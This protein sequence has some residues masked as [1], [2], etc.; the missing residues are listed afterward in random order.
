MLDSN[1]CA[2]AWHFF[3]KLSSS[4]LFLTLNSC[5]CVASG[6]VQFD[7]K[8]QQLHLTPAAKARL[9]QF[10]ADRDADY[11]E[12]HGG[13]AVADTAAAARH[14]AVDYAVTESY[15]DD[16]PLAQSFHQHKLDGWYTW[17]LFVQL[18]PVCS[19]AIRPPVPLGVC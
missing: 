6:D 13:G 10:Q 14:D 7:I 17:Y 19:L 2:V 8:F 16:E 5:N 18:T 15:E 12:E 11:A 4:S 1:G 3:V 9:A